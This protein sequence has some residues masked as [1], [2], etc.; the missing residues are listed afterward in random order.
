MSMKAIDFGSFPV[1]IRSENLNFSI[2]I[3]FDNTILLKC[4]VLN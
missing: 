2:A 4:G 1:I 3:D